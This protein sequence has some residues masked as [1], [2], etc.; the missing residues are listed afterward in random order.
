MLTKL[1]IP[2]GQ[3]EYHLIEELDPQ[4]NEL[5]VRCEFWNEPDDGVKQK[6]LQYC[7]LTCFCQDLRNIVERDGWTS[8]HPSVKGVLSRHPLLYQMV[9]GEMPDSIKINS[10]E[11]L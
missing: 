8:I 11:L 4:D 1:Y 7:N 6:Y 5:M 10:L 3:G 2:L 9:I